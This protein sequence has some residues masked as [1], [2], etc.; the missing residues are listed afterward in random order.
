MP[1]HVNKPMQEK[2]S[3][4]NVSQLE[5]VGVEIV[6]QEIEHFMYDKLVYAIKSF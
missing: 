6:Y 1:I 5:S 3:Y 4:L 2:N